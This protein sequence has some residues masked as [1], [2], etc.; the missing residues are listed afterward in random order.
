[1][2]KSRVVGNSSSEASARLPDETIYL[3]D[4]EEHMP[5]VYKN[6]CLQDQRLMMS[7]S[8]GM[9]KYDKVDYDIDF[10][11]KEQELSLEKP[12]LRSSRKMR[13]GRRKRARRR[14]MSQESR[15]I[16]DTECATYYGDDS[17]E[18]SPDSKGRSHF[19]RRRKKILSRG[20][21]KSFGSKVR[22]AFNEYQDENETQKTRIM[23]LVTHSRKEE[24]IQHKLQIC[25]YHDTYGGEV[26]MPITKRATTMPAESGI[27]DPKDSISRSISFPLEQ[28]H[29]NYSSWQP[30]HPNL[31][32]YDDLSAKFVALKRENLQ[33][34]HHFQRPQV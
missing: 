29:F 33:H 31:P 3:D 19:Q 6:E 25:K 18:T 16:T 5:P 32:D 26:I 2:N 15:I 27:E 30:I 14:S 4:V 21:S 8:F 12:V 20:S 28:P 11:V 23:N 10:Y 17:E 1:M 13:K 7:K 34:K 22:N 9:S 24:A